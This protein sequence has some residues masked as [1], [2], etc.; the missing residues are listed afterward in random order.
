VNFR[1]CSPFI[2]VTYKAGIY[3]WSAENRPWPQM[4]VPQPPAVFIIP[5]MRVGC[6]PFYAIDLSTLECFFDETCLNTTARWISNLP[7]SAWPKALNRSLLSKFQPT[8]SIQDILAEDMVDQ[9]NNDASFSKYYAA[10]SPSECTYTF[11]RRNDVLVV[12]TTLIGL[13]GGLMVS[14]RMLAPLLVQCAQ[15][16]HGLCTTPNQTDPAHEGCCSGRPLRESL[17]EMSMHRLYL[18]DARLVHRDTAAG[19]SGQGKVAL[20]E[21]IRGKREEVRLSAWR[22]FRRLF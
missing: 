4:M 3:N 22:Y 18:F 11:T 17:R 20:L 8:A 2:P 6:A 9:W 21:P 10:C 12:L 1:V 16:V 5:G 7:A 19:G 13:F 14:M 15:R